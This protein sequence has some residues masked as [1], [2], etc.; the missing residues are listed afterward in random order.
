MER[1]LKTKLLSRGEI[2]AMKAQ[3]LA[4][5]HGPWILIGPQ[6]S[7]EQWAAQELAKL[8]PLPDE[9]PHKDIP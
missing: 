4:D 2:Q 8:N 9:T 1:Q 7:A 5:G 6:M 3:M